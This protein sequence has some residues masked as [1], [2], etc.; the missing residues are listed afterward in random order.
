[1][2]IACKFSSII[3]QNASLFFHNL[4]IF[5]LASEPINKHLKT[6]GGVFGRRENQG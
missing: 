4:E 6:I 5:N 1:M 2:P 3:I